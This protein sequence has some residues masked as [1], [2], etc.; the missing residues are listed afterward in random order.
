MIQ[1]VEAGEQVR[2]VIVGFPGFGGLNSG[3]LASEGYHGGL[4]EVTQ[5]ITICSGQ[6]LLPS[7]RLLDV[8]VK[9]INVGT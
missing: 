9:D 1:K 7:C 4:V 2:L 5:E 3:F 8:T 6:V